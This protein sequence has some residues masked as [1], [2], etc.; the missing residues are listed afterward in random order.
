MSAKSQLMWITDVGDPRAKRDAS[1]RSLIKKHVMKD[2]GKS[3]RRPQRRD[4]SIRKHVLSSGAEPGRYTFKE[5]KDD[6]A[7]SSPSDEDIG[8]VVDVLHYPLHSDATR[9]SLFSRMRQHPSFVNQDCNFHAE[10]WWDLSLLD[11]AAK[12]QI[13]S[14]LATKYGFL[15]LEPGIPFDLDGPTTTTLRLEALRATQRA[16]EDPSR[17]YSIGVITAITA[18]VFEA[19]TRGDDVQAFLHLCGLRTLLNHRQGGLSSLRAYPKLWIMISICEIICATTW[20]T[21]PELPFPMDYFQEPFLRPTRPPSEFSSMVA[22]AWRSKQRQTNITTRT[23]D[24]MS[25]YPK[26]LNNESSEAYSLHPRTMITIFTGFKK[27]LSLPCASLVESQDLR[28]NCLRTVDNLLAT[29]S[30]YEDKWS[31]QTSSTRSL[32]WSGQ[33][34]LK[35]IILVVRC[36]NEMHPILNSKLPSTEANVA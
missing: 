13:D 33:D 26:L 4:L 24:H 16:I 6:S 23:Y 12:S 29:S 19:H 25:H 1:T 28:L 20:G 21:V 3:R 30:A 22:T 15:M 14:M 31:C 18:S 27:W 10:M 11:P 7:S 2:I 36:G 17:C 35:L 32:P 8:R 5:V 9:P 34:V